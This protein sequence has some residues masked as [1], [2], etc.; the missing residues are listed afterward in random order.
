[1]EKNTQD[2][3]SLPITWKKA[4]LYAFGWLI[5]T[6]ILAV[7]PPLAVELFDIDMS[8]PV[9]VILLV[10]SFILIFALV[11]ITTKLI[12]RSWRVSIAFLVELVITSV[13]LSLTALLIFV[14]LMQ[15]I[16]GPYY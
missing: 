11:I 8:K 5:C 7:I 4:R 13:L 12:H 15:G 14:A 1:M 16:S 3:K 6:G 10:L 9:S 2:K